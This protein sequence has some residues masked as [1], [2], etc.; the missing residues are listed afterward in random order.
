MIKLKDLLLSTGD[1]D[2]NP[3]TFNYKE[4]FLLNEMPSKLP[5]RDWSMDDYIKNNYD[6]MR[7]EKNDKF[8]KIY[9][10]GNTPLRVYLEQDENTYHYSLLDKD[11]P[12]INALHSFDIIK[13]PVIG[14]ENRE[15]W[16]SHYSRGLIR[17]WMKDEI[18]PN[19]DNMMSDKVLSKKG[20][21]FW[22]TLFDDY[23]KMDVVNY[24]NAEVV[25]HINDKSEMEHYYD[26][27]KYGFRFVLRNK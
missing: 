23:G 10:F 13:Y 22:Q 4:F 14:I 9:N 3:Y 21:K 11:K 5:P 16:N 17:K 18:I 24:Y 25:C 12:Y 27:E 26:N 2:F 1:E 20:F 8:I 19:Y 6:G 7:I 15:I